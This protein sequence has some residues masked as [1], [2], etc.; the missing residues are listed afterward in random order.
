MLNLYFRN[1]IPKVF[2]YAIL[3]SL[4]LSACGTTNNPIEQPSKST[5]TPITTKKA[6]SSS[7]S[8][9]TRTPIATPEPV[10]KLGITSEDLDGIEIEIWHSWSDTAGEEFDRLIKDFN[11]TNEWN[12]KAE[13]SYQGDYDRTYENLRLSLEDGTRPDVVIGY[14]YQALGLEESEEVFVDIGAYINDPV[15]GLNKDERSD[16][17]PVFWD[18]NILEDNHIGIPTQGSGQLIYYNETWAEDL[19]FTSPPS[20]PAEFKQQACAAARHNNQDDDPTNDHTGGWVISTDYSGMLG[21]LYAFGGEITDPEGDGYQFNTQ[22]VKDALTFL[23]DMY[24]DGCAWLSDSQLPESEFANRL[25]LFASGSVAGI[26]YQEAAFAKAESRDEWTVIPFPSPDGEAVIVVYGP[27]F[28]FLKTD[29]AEQLASWLLIKWLTS[30]ENQAGLSQVTGF[31]P[32]RRSSLEH[33]D[34]LP[35]T[36][37]QWAEAVD[38]LSLARSEPSYSSWRTVRWA[39]SDAATQLY[40]YYFTIDQVPSLARLLDR[41][42]ND[43]HNPNEDQ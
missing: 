18:Q 24:D 32:V 9:P 29:A 34:I 26:P 7:S 16:F 42:A 21:W 15:W 3:I 31:F 19:G 41:T 35:R 12:I 40:R 33:L 30:P 43:L 6:T 13:S 25:G 22:E 17:I 1:N 39:V 36:Y 10:S 14:N 20:T 37:P 28:Q 5:R 27:S 8:K 4:V 38:L 2:I 23:R 11:K